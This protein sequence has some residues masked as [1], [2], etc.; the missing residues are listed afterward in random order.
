MGTFIWTALVTGFRLS[1][2]LE[3]LQGA[4]VDDL[5]TIAGSAL[6]NNPEIFLCEEGKD[7]FVWKLREEARRTYLA[8]FL[9]RYYKDF[10]GADIHYFNKHCKPVIDYLLTSPTN[11]QL[12]EWEKDSLSNVF[13]SDEYGIREVLIDRKRINMR[14]SSVRLSHEGKVLYEKLERHLTF[15]EHAMRTAYAD[16]PIGGCLIVEVG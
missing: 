11:E 8:S 4:D 13:Y 9:K 7:F 14:F 12:N 5:T 6:V 10:Y 15:F 1:K 2:S 16:N 3:L